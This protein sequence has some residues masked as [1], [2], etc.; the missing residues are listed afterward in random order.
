MTIDVKAQNATGRK[1]KISQGALPRVIGLHRHVPKRADFSW[2]SFSPS[3]V[4]T[5]HDLPPYFILG[6]IDETSFTVGAD[7]WAATWQGTESDTH[8]KVAY[9]NSEHRYELHQTWSGVNG[10]FS[11]FTERIGL[12]TFIL[13]GLYRR[14]PS[15]W[16]AKAKEHLE[17]S[18]QL[19]YVEQ[20]EEAVAICGLPDGAFRTIAFPVAVRNIKLVREWLSDVA[21]EAEMPYP[22]SAFTR[23]LVQAINYLEGSAPEWTSD[24]MLVF[25]KSLTDTGLPPL[26]L[27]IKETAAD[28]TSAW[29]VRRG[30]YVVFI[31]VP[32][33]GLTHLLEQLCNVNG[34]IRRQH[35]EELSIELQPVVMP[36]RFD[37]LAQSI[38]SWDK[39]HTTRTTMLLEYKD[40]SDASGDMLA[41]LQSQSTSE[42]LM[43][44]AQDISRNLIAPFNEVFRNVQGG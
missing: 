43:L 26:G 41:S 38:S 42:A 7:G 15:T 5:V 3:E 13:R 33:A 32:F 29:T 24:P 12:D 37:A 39:K 35:D 6:E 20:P 30:V 28:G 27:P 10:G 22:F 9:S 34:P 36:G 44:A 18:Y 23:L 2:K 25:A 31:T 1:R 19:T 4:R 8:F 16:D 17:T 14:F 21:R 40:Q 11:I